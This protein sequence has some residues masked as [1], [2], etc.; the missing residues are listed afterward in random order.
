MNLVAWES[1]DETLAF[2]NGICFTDCLAAVLGRLRLT[3]NTDAL[4]QSNKLEYG[5]SLMML[6]KRSTFAAKQM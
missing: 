6:W 4:E 5:L 3:N 2:T 1:R